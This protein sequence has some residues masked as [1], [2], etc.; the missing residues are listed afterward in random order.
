MT[1]ACGCV[2]RIAPLPGQPDSRNNKRRV[3]AGPQHL[4]NRGKFVLDRLDLDV[5]GS[6]RLPT[7]AMRLPTHA[8]YG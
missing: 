4:L 5:S 2:P 3:D 7:N 1:S 6:M 8:M